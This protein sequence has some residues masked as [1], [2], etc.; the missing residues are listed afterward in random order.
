MIFM[1]NVII[2]WRVGFVPVFNYLHGNCG[3]A[4][5]KL[6]HAVVA[7]RGSNVSIKINPPP[8]LEIVTY[9]SELL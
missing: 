3:R 6:D 7:P 1:T 8:L 4:R 2:I 9:S 5:E